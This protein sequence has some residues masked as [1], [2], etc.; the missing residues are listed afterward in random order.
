MSSEEDAAYLQAL[1][2]LAQTKTVDI[3]RVLVLRSGSN[4]TLP[5]VGKTAADL[6]A[7]EANAGALS[8]FPE[9]VVSTFQT[10]RVV[11]DELS[12]N[13]KVYRDHIPGTN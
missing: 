6:L 8:G 1:T 2:F 3:N 5:P 13:W 9:S 10:G 11:V 4:F 7:A 12:S